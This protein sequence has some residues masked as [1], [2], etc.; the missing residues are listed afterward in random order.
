MWDDVGVMAT[1]AAGTV[2]LSM[3][4]VLIAIAAPQNRYTQGRPPATPHLR[5]SCEGDCL[6]NMLL[7]K[8]VVGRS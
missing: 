2:S 6:D 5:G 3:A 7:R 8:W 1:P 4:H